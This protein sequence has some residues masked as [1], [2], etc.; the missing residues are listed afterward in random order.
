M[1]QGPD[2]NMFGSREQDIYGHRGR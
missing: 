1:I 2:L